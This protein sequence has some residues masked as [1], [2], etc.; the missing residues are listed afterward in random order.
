MQVQIF[1]ENINRRCLENITRMQIIISRAWS[2]NLPIL[3]SIIRKISV[4]TNQV[5]IKHRE[6]HCIGRPPPP[7]L[8][9]NSRPLEHILVAVS[10]HHAPI[11][12][13]VIFP[14]ILS[15]IENV[16]WL[17]VTYGARKSFSCKNCN[18]LFPVFVKVNQL[19]GIF[20]TSKQTDWTLQIYKIALSFVSAL[21]RLPTFK[22][23]KTFKMFKNKTA[24]SLETSRS[25]CYYILFKIRMH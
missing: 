16:V 13:N 5:I 19:Y 23:L 8:S 17:Q 25:N 12:H 10:G 15:R 22:G 20:F 21:T 3:H 7:G 1:I 24:K 18:Q 2:S 4:F 14:I 11:F 6:I 9:L